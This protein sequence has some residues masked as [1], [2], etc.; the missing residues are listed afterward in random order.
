MARL[1]MVVLWPS[2]L[3]AIVAEG[4]F[5]SFFDPYDLTLDGMH[6]GLTPLAVYSVGFF[7]FWAFCALASM[8]TWYLA[9]VPNDQRMPL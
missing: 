4:F 5:F 1:M 2:F 6:L 7:C 9:N 3:V 8:L